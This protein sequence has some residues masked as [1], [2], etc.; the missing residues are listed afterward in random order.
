[1]LAVKNCWVLVANLLNGFVDFLPSIWKSMLQLGSITAKM[2]QPALLQFVWSFSSYPGRHG[3]GCAAVGCLVHGQQVQ[4]MS[5]CGCVALCTQTSFDCLFF[6]SISDL[7]EALTS[8]FNFQSGNNNA[9]LR[10]MCWGLIEQ[11]LPSFI[12]PHSFR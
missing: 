8:L 5:H 2:H 6:S 4:S 9:F 1:M 11:F 3:W 12:F 7:G 10:D